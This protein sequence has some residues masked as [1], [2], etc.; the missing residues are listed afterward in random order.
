MQGVFVVVVAGGP[1]LAD[2]VH[3]LAGA[4]LGTRVAV[5]GGGLIV[6]VAVIALAVQAPSFWRYRASS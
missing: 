2:L 3:G 5:T 6:V 4:A 1:R